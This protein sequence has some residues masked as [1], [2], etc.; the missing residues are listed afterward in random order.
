MGHPKWA[1]SL[2]KLLN[3]II[4]PMDGTPIDAQDP[5][6]RLHSVNVFVH[7]QERSI[8]FYL[9]QL[10]FHVA[11]DTR[12]QSGE[13]WVA[14]APPDGSA[15]LSLVAPE[16]HSKQYPLIGRSTQIVFITEDVTAKFREWDVPR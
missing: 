12:L 10:G 14:V 8:R 16:P 1:D 4:T 6:L 2:A 15:I 13:R 11:F 5:L 3:F 7:D 9:D